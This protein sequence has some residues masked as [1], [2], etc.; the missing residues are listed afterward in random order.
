MT[1]LHSMHVYHADLKPS[2]ILISNNGVLKIADFGLSVHDDGSGSEIDSRST[3]TGTAW[4]MSPERLRGA[5]RCNFA[6]FE[7]DDVW[8]FGITLREM[9]THHEPRD[10]EKARFN[11]PSLPEGGAEVVSNFMRSVF[12]DQNDRP[13]FANMTDDFDDIAEYIT[14]ISEDQWI[15]EIY[16]WRGTSTQ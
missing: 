7:K 11:A 6:L 10:R 4:Y 14:K 13:S 8:A 12:Q 15:E 5:G 2:N 1:Y 16:K 3:T 9:I